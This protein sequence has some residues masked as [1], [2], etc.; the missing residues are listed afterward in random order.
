M[1]SSGARD[2]LFVG[3]ETKADP[4]IA[5]KQRDLRMTPKEFFSSL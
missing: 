1:R 5:Q 3:V 4:S 2:L